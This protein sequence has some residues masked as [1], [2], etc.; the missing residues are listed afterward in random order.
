MFNRVYV[1]DVWKCIYPK[2]NVLYSQKATLACGT[3]MACYYATIHTESSVKLAKIIDKH[4]SKFPWWLYRKNNRIYGKYWSV[5]WGSEKNKCKCL[6]YSKI[7]HLIMSPLV[8][9]VNAY[10]KNVRSNILKSII[11]INKVFIF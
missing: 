1:V 7:L 6:N 8:D 3:T 4:E 5:H 2:P 11:N 9:T 10:I